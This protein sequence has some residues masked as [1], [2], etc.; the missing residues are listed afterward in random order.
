MKP[1]D[2]L[3]IEEAIK[4]IDTDTPTNPT[5]DNV[6]LVKGIEYLRMNMR[7][8]ALNYSIHLVKKNEQGRIVP[9][10]VKWAV[11]ESARDANTLEYA[12]MDHYKS[13]SGKEAPDPESLGLE[14]FETT[15][16]E[17]HKNSVKPRHNTESATKKGSDLK[18]GTD[19][20]VT[21]GK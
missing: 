10:G 17:K 19:T 15:M 8:G 9:N 13:R 18:Q 11:V 6:E 16:D 12:I 2:F 3:T 21:G 20:V 4:L 5:V 14:T 7:G 1:K